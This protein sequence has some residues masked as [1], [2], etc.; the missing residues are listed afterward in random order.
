MNVPDQIKLIIKL[1]E[2]EK[3]ETDKCKDCKTCKVAKGLKDRV[4]MLSAQVIAEQSKI[5]NEDPSVHVAVNKPKLPPSGLP[6]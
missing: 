6:N 2:L 4:I 5:I 1:M 3:L